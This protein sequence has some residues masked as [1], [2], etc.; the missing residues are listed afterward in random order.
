[1]KLTEIKNFVALTE[2]IGTSGQPSIDQFKLISDAGYQHVINIATADNNA[3]ISNEAEI[4]TLLGMNYFQIPVPYHNPE[5]KHVLDFCQL[6]KALDGESVF[7]HCIMNYRVSAFMFHYL[8]K[9]GNLEEQ[10]AR[11]PIFDIWQPEPVW[12][13][14]LTWSAKDIGLKDNQN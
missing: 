13:E 4:V 1:M 10:E 5:P 12:H 8:S 11:S 2:K 7:V 9:V 6:M 14:L 3:S